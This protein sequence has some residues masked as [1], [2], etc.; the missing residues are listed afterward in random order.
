[1]KWSSPSSLFVIAAAFLSACSSCPH[2]SDASLRAQF[3]SHKAE[4]N[5]LARMAQENTC[6]V[7]I[8]FD[9][10][11]PDESSLARCGVTTER[12]REYRSLLKAVGAQSGLYLRQNRG[13][14]GFIMSAYGLAVTG[15]GS[16]KGI[17]LRTHAT[18]TTEEDSCTCEFDATDQAESF[19]P[20][21][22]NWYIAFE[23]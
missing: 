5:Q 2:P 13:E 4:F 16:S 8:D 19:R 15:S 12:L 18:I 6:I 1:M 3:K 14:I 11:S 10:T 22:G 9:W 17:V 7:R 23:C 20:I 21:E